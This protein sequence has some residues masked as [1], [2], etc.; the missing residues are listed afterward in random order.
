MPDDRV[1]TLSRAIAILDCFSAESPQLGVREVARRVNLSHSAAGRLMQAMRDM[2]I[3]NQDA[4]TSLYSM[5]SR[6]LVW[7]GVYASNLDVRNVA[8]PFIHELHH[9]TQETI[10]LYLME[11]NER[12]CV[13][14]LESPQN[15]RIV[16]RIGRRLPLYAGSAGK[17]FLAFLPVA[18]RDEILASTDFVPLTP[19]TI[20]DRE[21]L[22]SELDIIKKQGYSVSKGEWLMDASGV[23]APIFDQ[24]GLVIAAM[25]ISGPGQRFTSEKIETYSQLITQVARQISYE[26]G[27]RSVSNGFRR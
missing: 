24:T 17:V 6:P 9:D 3:L 21:V 19:R 25:T 11:G 18:R 22:I 4:N 1:H 20:V 5:G 27:Y 8:L 14:R 13:E 26:L 15:V 2:G 16:A 7:A 23:A 12:V 10:S